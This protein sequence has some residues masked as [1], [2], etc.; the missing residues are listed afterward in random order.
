MI[1]ADLAA[2]APFVA[3]PT[4]ASIIRVESGGKPFA[5]NVNRGPRVPTPRSAGEAAQV[6]RYWIARGHSVDLGL[7]QVN[8]RN[9]AR[10]GYS[11]EQMFDPC[12]NVRAG[13]TILAANYADAA[14]RR[15]EGQG[16]LLDALSAYNTGS[17]SRGYSNGYVGRY[18]NMTHSN[19]SIGAARALPM[20]EA[21]D[22]FSAETSVFSRKD[23]VDAG[24]GT[25]ASA[26]A[27][28]PGFD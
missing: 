14:K 18:F 15:G 23:D 21:P 4:L 19:I 11:V 13:A 16:A 22:P 27:Q 8:N 24:I 10:L 6:A 28:P 1:D 5:I 17:F 12:L 20:P 25:V 3:P 9:L 7:M 2:C 26:A